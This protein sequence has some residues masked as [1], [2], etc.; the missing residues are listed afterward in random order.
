MTVRDKAFTGSI[1]EVYERHLVPLIFEPYAQDLAEEVRRL[2]PSSVLETAA[3]TGVV[4][5]ALTAVLPPAARLVAT[6]LNMAMLNVARAH[7]L[8]E[9]PV[10]WRQA[11]ALALPV[12]FPVQ[13]AATSALKQVALKASMSPGLPSR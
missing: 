10:E 13:A 2:K 4:T 5:R 6:D 3:G 9:C 7:F 8:R 11:D 12:A 1:P